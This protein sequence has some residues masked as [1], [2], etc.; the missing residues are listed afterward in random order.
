MKKA[1]SE[2]LEPHHGWLGTQLFNVLSRFAPSRKAL[3]YT[4]SLERYN[5]DKQV[6]KDMRQYHQKMTAC[7]ARLT[8]FYAKHQLENLF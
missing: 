6:L 4:L 7:V 5:K 8:E 1:Y 3:F 2:T